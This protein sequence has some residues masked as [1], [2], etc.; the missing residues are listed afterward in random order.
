L[1]LKPDEFGKLQPGEYLAMV[2]GHDLAAQA[3]RTEKAYFTS[4]VIN[5]II[6]AHSGR[7]ARKSDFLSVGDLLKPFEKEAAKE[8]ILS[9]KER[10]KKVFKR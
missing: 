9:E 5:Y 8:E 1:G 7:K 4:C 6:A 10:L 3:R 2:K